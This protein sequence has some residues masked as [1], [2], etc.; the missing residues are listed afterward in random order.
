MFCGKVVHKRQLYSF[1]EVDKNLHLQQMQFVR[2]DNLTA[3][4][5]FIEMLKH[6]KYS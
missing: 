6:Q 1:T 3:R 2:L 5:N 4:H